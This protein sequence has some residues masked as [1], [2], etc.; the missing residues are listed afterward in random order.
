MKKK[1]LIVVL[2]IFLSFGIGFGMSPSVFAEDELYPDTEME[3]IDPEE[4]QN[5]EDETKDSSD[6]KTSDDNNLL[7]WWVLAGLSVCGIAASIIIS[8]K[9]SRNEK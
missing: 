4:G 5:T 9:R 6:V 7:I 3:M 1:L 8:R 2:S